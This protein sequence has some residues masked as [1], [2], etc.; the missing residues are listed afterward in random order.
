MEVRE[1]P[2]ALLQSHILELLAPCPSYQLLS[3]LFLPIKASLT[4]HSFV[5]FTDKTGA[6]LI[7]DD[8][9]AP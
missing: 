9:H 1:Q 4:F 6:D 2:K 3:L 7:V 8:I 5:F